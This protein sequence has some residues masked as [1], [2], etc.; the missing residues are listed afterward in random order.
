M[1]WNELITITITVMISIFLKNEQEWKFRNK[2][3]NWPIVV[4]NEVITT[5]ITITITISISL[6]NEQFKVDDKKLM[7]SIKE[8][9]LTGLT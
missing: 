5:T 3:E 6:K 8:C 4:W 7:D 9:D 1:S 2:Y